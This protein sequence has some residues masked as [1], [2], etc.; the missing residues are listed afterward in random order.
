[1]IDFQP[2][3]MPLVKEPVGSV[4]LVVK[5]TVLKLV[6]LPDK[7]TVIKAGLYKSVTEY[8]ELVKAAN[9]AVVYCFDPVAAE[10]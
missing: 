5:L 4:G 2:L 9:E 6:A 7:V 3:E 1:M 8:I 10:L